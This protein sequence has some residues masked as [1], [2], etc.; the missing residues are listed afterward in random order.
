MNGGISIVKIACSICQNTR[1]IRI[2]YSANTFCFNC[3]RVCGTDV[4]ERGTA[5][6]LNAQELGRLQAYRA[7]VQA[8]VYTDWPDRSLGV[9]YL[10]RRS[11]AR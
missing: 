4:A 2:G 1:T 9:M 8:G 5:P 7:A 6:V 11:A 10:G 3:R